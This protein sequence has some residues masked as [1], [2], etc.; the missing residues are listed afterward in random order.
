MQIFV[1]IGKSFVVR[2]FV[3]RVLY[4]VI[5]FLLPSVLFARRK[6]VKTIT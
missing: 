4:R 6:F 5:F 1:D 2:R 3:G